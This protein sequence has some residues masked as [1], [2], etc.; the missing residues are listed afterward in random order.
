MFNIGFNAFVFVVKIQIMS[1]AIT[2]CPYIK[3]RIPR[4][5]STICPFVK[6]SLWIS[7][8]KN[9]DVCRMRR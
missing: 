5:V 1:Q 3:Y 9:Y 2:T 4:I 6:I 8:N 7:L